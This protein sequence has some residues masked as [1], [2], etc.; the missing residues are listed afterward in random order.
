MK[1]DMQRA[2]TLYQIIQLMKESLKQNNKQSLNFQYLKI[3]IPVL[4][5]LIIEIRN[6]AMQIHKIVMNSDNMIKMGIDI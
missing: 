1:R 6:L 3:I 5:S 4:F 2:A